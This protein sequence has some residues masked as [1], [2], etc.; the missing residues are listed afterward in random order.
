[1]RLTGAATAAAAAALSLAGC[2]GRQSAL[3][4]GGAD[5]AALGTLFWVMLGGA[6]LLW[7][8]MNGMFFYVTRVNASAMPR[9]LANGM[10][11]GGGIVL[12]TILLGALLG[13]GLS[14]LPDQRQPDDGLT[15]RVHGE[16]WWWR[17]EYW[18][19]GAAAPVVSANEIR[20]PVGERVGF[21]LDSD[22]VIH[23]FWIPSLG[24]KMD[25]FPG[26]ETYVSLEAEAPGVY[27]GQCAEF[28][29][30]S[31]AW[32]AFEA[33]AMPP[34][35][36]DAWLDAE[37]GAAAA[38]EGGAAERGA[39]LFAREGC[40]ACHAI[41]G[42]GHVGQVGPD[43]TH[44]GGRRSIGAGRLAATPEAFAAWI[45]HTDSLKPGVRMPSYDHLS[46]A[47]AAALA[48]YLAGLT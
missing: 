21:R 35:A 37:A 26:R 19:E 13:W 36:F 6:V 29:G 9:R 22:Q 45:T 14:I 25:M 33:V 46:D 30:E 28:C 23:S 47:D 5:A 8:A 27:R 32:M 11:I 38:P 3:S 40:G 43:L 24:G 39:A 12:P 42:T 44:V 2:A 1:M 16:Q 7:L 41:R 48:A 34:D 18:P 10:V 20:L 17:V 15:I 31:H 4:P